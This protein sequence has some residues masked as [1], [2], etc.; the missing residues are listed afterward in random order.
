MYNNLYNY[1]RS[2]ENLLNVQYIQPENVCRRFKNKASMNFVNNKI[3]FDKF[4]LFPI[5]TIGKDSDELF[6]EKI[7]K[8]IKLEY[9]NIKS[10]TKIKKSLNS[11]NLKNDEKYKLYRNI[12]KIIYILKS[13]PESKPEDWLIITPIVQNNI[14]ANYLENSI[15]EYWKSVL[16][17]KSKLYCKLFKSSD[18]GSIDL[19]Q[20][21]GKT[22][23]MSI[24]ASKGQTSKYVINIDCNNNTLKRW[25]GLDNREKL[26]QISLLHVA[27]T[28]HSDMLFRFKTL[29][30]PKEKINKIFK[31]YLDINLLYE[32]QEILDLFKNEKCYQ[33]FLNNNS[34]SNY[35]SNMINYNDK[36]LAYNIMIVLGILSLGHKSNN[37]IDFS[38]QCFCEKVNA[39]EEIQIVYNYRDYINLISKINEINKNYTNYEKFKIPILCDYDDYIENS[40][41]LQ[42]TLVEYIMKPISENKIM[43][44]LYN[45][46]SNSPTFIEKLLSYYYLYTIITDPFQMI[47]YHNDILYLL[48]YIK[49]KDIQEKYRVYWRN[50]FNRFKNYFEALNKQNYYYLN[51]NIIYNDKIYKIKFSQKLFGDHESKGD[52]NI[53]VIINRPFIDISILNIN[54]R[55]LELIIN[56]Y[57]SRNNKKCYINNVIHYITL[58]DDNNIHT[59][60]IDNINKIEKYITEIIENIVKKE[61]N[62][63]INKFI[64]FVKKSLYKDNNSQS[65][66]KIKKIFKNYNI[67]NEFFKDLLDKLPL[68]ENKKYSY[69]QLIEK[70][71]NN[72]YNKKLEIIMN[73]FSES[74]LEE[75]STILLYKFQELLKKEDLEIPE[76]IINDYIK[77]NI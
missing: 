49:E 47:Y 32:N 13:Y 46:D 3:P 57:L 66:L 41:I 69:E 25:A 63:I 17:D 2:K 18:K 36:Y 58:N 72:Y 9:V 6:D 29:Y 24:H 5:S 35:N 70:I 76:N 53:D 38:I 73:T 7:K 77:E 42:H 51:R 61:S 59:L 21:I 68:C 8:I 4:K 60:C 56:A 54:I 50:N 71:N 40:K 39:I 28:R 37:K 43:E 48:G 75:D 62:K 74:E 65:G 22:Q 33:D 64:K 16:N 67:C 14:L 55:F 20:G 23:I 12:D 45:N 10:G 11:D 44:A 15:H 26:I 34:E 19:E 30:E 31:N 52:G 1:F 27:I